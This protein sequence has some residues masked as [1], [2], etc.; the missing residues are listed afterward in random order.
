MRR[1]HTD[2]VEIT[3]FIFHTE[4]VLNFSGLKNIQA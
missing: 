2:D 3:G 1:Q 4:A